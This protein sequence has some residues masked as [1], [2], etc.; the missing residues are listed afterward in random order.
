MKNYNKYYRRCNHVI[1]H[2]IYLNYLLHN[3]KF[4]KLIGKVNILWDFWF[5][6]IYKKRCSLYHCSIWL[7]RRLCTVIS[8]LLGLI[9]FCLPRLYLSI[10]LVYRCSK[11]HV[12][13]IRMR[14]ALALSS[15][16]M[17]RHP[18]HATS[19]IAGVDRA[20]RLRLIDNSWPVTGARDM[21]SAAR[22]RFD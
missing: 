4:S 10:T 3:V 20:G 14:M 2:E 15:R 18:P 5:F 7:S 19:L 11:S 1:I 16:A 21:A 17:H 22:I 9:R 13:A 12:V 8:V 6:Q